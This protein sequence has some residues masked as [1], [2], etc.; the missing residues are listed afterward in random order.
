MGTRRQDQCII[1]PPKMTRPS[2]KNP[3]Q[4]FAS[5]FIQFQNLIVTL[6]GGFVT[7]LFYRLRRKAADTIGAGRLQSSSIL[8]LFGYY[9]ISH[10][11]LPP[12]IHQT[13]HI[14]VCTGKGGERNDTLPSCRSA[15]S[16]TACTASSSLLWCLLSTS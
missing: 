12:E 6:V 16:S 14:P 3:K 5:N 2:R 13:A 15:L 8:H 10:C 11:N 4:P 1:N 9:F 7:T